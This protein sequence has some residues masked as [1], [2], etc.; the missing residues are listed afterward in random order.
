MSP[1]MS[2]SVFAAT[3]RGAITQSEPILIEENRYPRS[4]S[5]W[6]G[7]LSPRGTSV[8]LLGSGYRPGRHHPRL[9]DR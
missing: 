7:P 1:Q 4:R 3:G 9:P 2:A 6:K 8:R 5:V